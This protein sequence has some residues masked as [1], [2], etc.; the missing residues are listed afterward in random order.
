MRKIELGTWPRF[1]LLLWQDASYLSLFHVVNLLS[2]LPWPLRLLQKSPLDIAQS[3]KGSRV[4]VW[5]KIWIS[6]PRVASDPALFVCIIRQIGPYHLQ[7]LFLSERVSV[8][9]DRAL[10]T[11]TGSTPRNYLCSKILTLNKCLCVRNPRE[12]RLTYQLLPWPGAI[13]GPVNTMWSQVRLRTAVTTTHRGKF[14]TLEIRICHDRINSAWQPS[15]RMTLR[16]LTICHHHRRSTAYNRGSDIILHNLSDFVLNNLSDI[17]SKNLSDIISNNLSD[18]ILNNLSDIILNN[19]SDI[20]LNNLGDIILNNPRDIISNNL[21][22]I[23]LN[24]LSICSIEG[25]LRSII[26]LTWKLTVVLL[27][28]CMPGNIF[29]TRRDWEIMRISE[30]LRNILQDWLMNT[31]MH[32]WQELRMDDLHCGCMECMSS[33]H[34]DGVP[35]MIVLL[36]RLTQ[37]GMRA[38]NTYTQLTLHNA[39]ILAIRRQL[40]FRMQTEVISS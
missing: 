10:T 5:K 8:T 18:I 3:R 30:V 12:M 21:S 17:I 2:I 35:Y 29:L 6:G 23:I 28:S 20:I 9:N 4:I 1:Q 31:L 38:L 11:L 32:Y 37:P 40:S 34:S 36:R 24:N 15:L 19:L 33:N 16:K 26:L 13:G 22:D 14:M 7:L 25:W 39:Q 27:R